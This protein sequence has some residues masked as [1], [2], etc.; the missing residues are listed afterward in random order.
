MLIKLS[1]KRKIFL[2]IPLCSSRFVT[3]RRPNS[4]GTGA[5]S[6]E[7]RSKWITQLPCQL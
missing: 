6:L 7:G 2:P 4:A 3:G 1:I 5:N